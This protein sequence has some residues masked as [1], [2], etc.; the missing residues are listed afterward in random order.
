MFTGRRVF[1]TLHVLAV[2]AN[3]T[4]V[5][6][7]SR[8]APPAAT[9]NSKRDAEPS[10]EVTMSMT[11]SSTAFAAGQR[12]PQKFTGEG[13]DV[14][15]A[16][17]WTGAPPAAVEFALICDDPD[18]PRPEPWV[19]WVIAKIPGHVTTLKEGRPRDKTLSDPAGAVQG[20]NSW[21]SDNLGYRGPMPPPGHGTHHYHFRLYALDAA[22][23][24]SPGVTKGQ[25]QAAMKGHVLAETEVVGTYERED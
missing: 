9:E 25:L 16:L 13:P 21:P 5:A 2:L 1:R 8:A 18:A 20:L 17:Q 23:P 4:L 15:P 19:H 7:C 11:I 3:G 12:I 6:G 22:L 14:S 24:V 10:G